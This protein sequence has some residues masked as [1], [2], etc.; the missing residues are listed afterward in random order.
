MTRVRTFAAAVVASSALSCAVAAWAAGDASRG[1]TLYHV[2]YACTDCHVASPKPGDIVASGGSVSGLTSAIQSVPEMRSRFLSTLGQSATDLADVAAYIA[3]V[4][5]SVIA[6]PDLDQHGF[7]GSW[8][9][10]ATSGQGIEV[11][12]FPDMAAPGTALVAGAWFTYDVAPAGGDDRQR[13]YTFIGDARRGAAS[14]PV[15]IYRNVG[16]N[17]DALPTTSSTTV[18][19]G[20]LS[21]TDCTN[22]TFAYTFTD[23]R[24]G[25]IPV[26]RITP[27]VTCAANGTPGTS[28]DF[29][30]SGNWYDPAKSGQ[31][32]VFE[33]NPVAPV[34]F[35]TWYTYAPAGQ[36]AGVAGQRWFTGQATYTPGSRTITA[37]LYETTGGVFDQPTTPPPSTDPVGTATVTLASCTSA[38]L[39]YAFTAGGNAGRSGTIALSRVGPVPAGCGP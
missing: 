24:T 17:F 26:T 20:T 19:S 23:G 5:S 15:T 11:E 3:S 16:G 25:S 34:F 28:A 37:T 27:N 9:E 30:F 2:T 13:W 29:A 39:N 38:Q 8:Y 14:V 32:F 10:P 33:V 4:T 21:F 6:G 1:T 35:F 7:T 18:G 22:G 31:G 36:A 12:F